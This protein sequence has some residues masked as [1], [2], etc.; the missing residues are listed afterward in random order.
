MLGAFGLL[1][2]GIAHVYMTTT[3]QT[4]LSNLR[5]MI[6]GYETGEEEKA[7]KRRQRNI[8]GLRGFIRQSPRQSGRRR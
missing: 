4:P 8:R 6:T 5:A 7:E 2:F 3:G 1:A